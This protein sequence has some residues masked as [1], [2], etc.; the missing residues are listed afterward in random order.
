MKAHQ[1]YLQDLGSIE[2]ST[3]DTLVVN[4][5]VGL[6]QVHVAP[7]FPCF[8]KFRI[9]ASTPEEVYLAMGAVG[10]LYCQSPKSEIVAKWF[11]HRARRKLLTVVSRFLSEVS[12]LEGHHRLS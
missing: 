9:D 10:G 8:E 11:L 2:D 1:Q 4:V 3:H 5:F 6:F 7:T 12:S